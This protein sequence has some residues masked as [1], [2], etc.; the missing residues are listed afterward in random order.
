MDM[1]QSTRTKL[2]IFGV[3]A[4]I[5]VVIIIAVLATALRGGGGGGSEYV[6][7]HPP[8]RLDGSQCPAE[9]GPR[10][11]LLVSLDGFR[12][13]F[14]GRNLTPSIRNLA[15]RGVH[16]EYLM[17]SYPTVTFPNHYTIVT[18]LLPESH[19]IIANSFYDPEFRE[20]FSLS[21]NAS[22]EGRWWGGEPIWNTVTRQGKKS[23]TFF[24]PG[25]GADINGRRPTYW[26]QY[27]TSIPF[28]DRVLQGLEWLS[29]PQDRR[30]SFVSLYFREPDHA[31]H[32]YGPDSKET[33]KELRRMEKIVN[34]LM[35]G[36][37]ERNLLNCVNVI[38]LSDHGATE[39]GEERVIDLK[40]YLPNLLEVARYQRSVVSRIGPKKKREEDMLKIMRNLTRIRDDN[41]MRVYLKE[42]LPKRMH[43]SKNHR[44]ED[45]LIEMDLGYTTQFNSSWALE[46]QHGYDNYYSAMNALFIAYGPDFKQYTKVK[47][48]QNI[49]LYNL[50][51]E[52]VAVKPAVNN[53]TWGSLHHLLAN[54]PEPPVDP[55]VQSPPVLRF[56]SVDLRTLWNESTCDRGE[57]VMEHWIPTLRLNATQEKQAEHKHLPWG[58][59]QSTSTETGDVALLYHPDHVT[60][61]SPSHKMPLW[62]SFTLNPESDDLAWFQPKM[63]S[64]MTDFR[65]NE[66]ITPSCEIF[67]ELEEFDYHMFILYPTTLS[68]EQN[69]DTSPSFLVSNAI[70][71]HS[72]LKDDWL[73]LMNLLPH[74]IKNY[75][76]LNILM[77]PIFD[78]VDNPHVSQLI[79]S[80]IRVPSD[81]FVILTRCLEEVTSLDLCHPMHL[82]TRTVILHQYTPVRNRFKSQEEHLEKFSAT[83]KDVEHFTRFRLYPKLSFADRVNLTLMSHPQF[84]WALP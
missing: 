35:T 13:D 47:P 82:D 4:F 51:C 66:T 14:L 55:E 10:P 46:G 5:I 68:V 45:I 34:M 36:L 70:P 77:G 63:S 62:T 1:A 56:P 26:R 52:M 80:Q 65:L 25:S 75:G 17:P 61:F 60:G 72:Y 81:L 42:G 58:I 9:Y 53:G 83:V 71:V 84:L 40:E 23:A 48:F 15:D 29:L 6:P 31:C 24:W 43:F 18:G 11:L 64:W 28:E 54:P 69:E 33:N 30:P 73:G 7:F 38:L 44:I 49:E 76:P 22:V 20:N 79:D 41:V 12:A 57:F 50:M 3:L 21:G 16:A 2:I 67:R 59:P 32:E 37:K 8:D 74:W 19:G 78:T 27:N 39:A